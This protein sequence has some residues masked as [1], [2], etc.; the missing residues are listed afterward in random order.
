MKKALIATASMVGIIV[1][2]IILAI[3]LSEQ[4]A[5]VFTGVSVSFLF[6]YFICRAIFIRKTAAN[7]AEAAK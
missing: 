4:I 6:Y 1:V 5:N 2:R 3:N 7:R